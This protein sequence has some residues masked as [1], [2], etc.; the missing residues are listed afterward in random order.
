MRFLLAYKD[1]TQKGSN[2]FKLFVEITNGIWVEAVY[3]GN[4]VPK[5]ITRLTLRGDSWIA[6]IQ[7][8]QSRDRNS[9]QF[10]KFKRKIA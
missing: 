10:K 1:K 3:F 7:K 8:H 5:A 6:E 2:Y 4:T 9:G